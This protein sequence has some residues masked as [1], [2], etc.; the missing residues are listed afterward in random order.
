MMSGMRTG[1]VAS[2]EIDRVLTRF[3]LN[4]SSSRVFAKP[5]GGT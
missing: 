2:E 1:S 3:S 4:H 5:V